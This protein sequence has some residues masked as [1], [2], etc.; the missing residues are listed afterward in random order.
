MAERL[1]PKRH[2]G[3][4]PDAE[5]GA[6]T[7]VE[8]SAG[9]G[10]TTDAT[11]DVGT[12]AGCDA[13]TEAAVDW[14]VV[15]NAGLVSAE[16]RRGFDNWLAASAEH[17][18]VW[19]QLTAAIEQT[20]GARPAAI[21]E[22]TDRGARAPASPRPAWRQGTGAGAALGQ[23]LGL[24]ERRSAARRRLLRGG[25]AL[26]LGGLSSAAA[27]LWIDRSLPLR[28]LAADLRTG[29]AERQ[30]VTLIEGSRLSLDAR[31][32]VDLSFAADRRLV[33]LRAG[34]V[35][36]EA[37]TGAGGASTGT[38]VTAPFLV[39]TAHGELSTAAARF[40]VR[41]EGP[42][43][44]VGVLDATVRLVTAAGEQRELQAGEA[45]R[46]SDEGIDSVGLPSPRAASA[47][48]HGMLE[49]HDQ[50][51]GEV[52]ESLRAYRRGLIRISER[53]AAIRLYGSY[54]LADT[55]RVLAL[56]AQTLPIRV[57]VYRGGWLVTIDAQA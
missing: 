57:Q 6:G 27:L 24:A 23:A 17:R 22:P 20:F 15:L 21:D 48:E 46:F 8:T 31:S 5:T 52:I 36:V 25:G 11:T 35:L 28:Q 26:A 56:L 19:R 53:A 55:D 45:A 47:W 13:I 38:P 32:A 43:S 2:A 50:P 9:T 10:A 4:D 16:D 51:L 29:T 34:A 30:T 39:R 18:A 41:D 1:D 12:D 44:F 33:Q 3:A 37:G 14:L 40:M 7:G 42:G 49:A 54:A